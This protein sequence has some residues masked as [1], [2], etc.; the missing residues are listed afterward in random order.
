MRV[1]I[2]MCVLITG[3][4]LA[5]AFDE[6][7]VSE[8]PAN[9]TADE[10][11]AADDDSVAEPE[12]S[13]NAEAEQSPTESAESDNTVEQVRDQAK[14]LASDTK[15]RVQEIAATIDQSQTAQ[16]VSAGLLKPVYLLAEAVSFPAFYWV[17]FMLMV[18]GTVSFAFQLV[19]GKVIVLAQGSMNVREIISD[20]AGLAISVLGLVLTT[21]AASQNSTFPQSPSS[22]VSSMLVG[23]LLG[24]FLYRW[25]QA[26][27]VDAAR[28]R[29][30]GPKK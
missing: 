24:L 25:G 26:E 16:E 30:R 18:A 14:E 13:A 3:H 10:L 22:V 4:P 8:E 7:G 27:E 21:Q 28:G 15:D 19:L 6:A 23:A 2:L 5:F 9:T 11:D 17:T 20:T 1:F 12:S 29:K